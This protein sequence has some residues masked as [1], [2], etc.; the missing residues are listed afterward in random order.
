MFSGRPPAPTSGAFT[1]GARRS[2]RQ[3][4]CLRR[5]GLDVIQKGHPHANQ[6]EWCFTMVI[7]QKGMHR[8]VNMISRYVNSMCVRNHELIALYHSIELL[9]ATFGEAPSPARYPHTSGLED[10]HLIAF[11]EAEEEEL[12]RSC[13]SCAV[14]ERVAAAPLSSTSRARVSSGEKPRR[15]VDVSILYM[16]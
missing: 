1:S 16:F 5:L 4:Q 15:C 3:G 9:N 7:N 11:T 14:L 10:V 8:L 6:C 13:S 12:P 2:G